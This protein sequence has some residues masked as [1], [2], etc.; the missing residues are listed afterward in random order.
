MLT[1][2]QIKAIYQY[3]VYITDK[4]FE[5][6]EFSNST[7]YAQHQAYGSILSKTL[8]VSYD[9]I[10]RVFNDWFMARFFAAYDLVNE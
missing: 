3:L 8:K 7:M 9:H 5:V 4:E 2:K 6:G 1:E 10:Y